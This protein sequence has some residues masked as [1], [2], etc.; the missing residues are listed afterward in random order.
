MYARILKLKIRKI[1]K[2]GRHHVSCENCAFGHFRWALSAQLCKKTEGSHVSPHTQWRTSLAKQLLNA[3]LSSPLCRS[4]D[5]LF[6][7]CFLLLFLWKTSKSCALKYFFFFLLRTSEPAF[8]SIWLAI[9]AI[10]IT[11]KPRFSLYWA[12]ITDIDIGSGGDWQKPLCSSIPS[13]S[14]QLERFDHQWQNAPPPSLSSWFPARVTRPRGVSWWESDARPS[15]RTSL[16]IEAVGPCQTGAIRGRR[17]GIGA[18][19]VLAGGSVSQEAR[20]SPGSASDRLRRARRTDTR[21]DLLHGVAE[22][23]GALVSAE[24]LI[25]L[26]AKK[27]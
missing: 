1:W 16:I 6:K 8:W 2:L 13:G 26:L 18:A 15:W 7:R 11:S 14:D 10:K 19:R 17:L 25:Q 4:A 21:F 20:E 24:K 5:I 27:R 9:Q 12:I 23:C 3:T 22:T